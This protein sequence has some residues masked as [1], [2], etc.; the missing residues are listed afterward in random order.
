MNR[1]VLLEHFLWT[2]WQKKHFYSLW[3]QWSL[4]LHK[5]TISSQ[6]GFSFSLNSMT[7]ALHVSFSL[8]LSLS[9][10]LPS[11]FT[12]FSQPN[13]PS[14]YF[15]LTDLLPL[16]HSSL[17]STFFSL[18]LSLSLSFSFSSSLRLLHPTS[19]AARTLSP[20]R[21]RQNRKLRAFPFSSVSFVFYFSF[22]YFTFQ[23][24]SQ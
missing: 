22:F 7:N 18:F 19:R 8:T 15:L 16:L 1:T 4:P 6:G 10:S 17:Y 14:C 12:L 24:K 11:S 5:S 9:S 13:H 3:R 20:S 2:L 21:S 23:R